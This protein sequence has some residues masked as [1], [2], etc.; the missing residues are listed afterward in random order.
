MLTL[1]GALHASLQ[2]EATETEAREAIHSLI[3]RLKLMPE[4]GELAIFLEDDLAGHLTVA[5]GGRTKTPVRFRTGVYG[6][7]LR[8]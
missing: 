3:T 6:A 5:S 2:N 1:L 4:N 7:W 8:G